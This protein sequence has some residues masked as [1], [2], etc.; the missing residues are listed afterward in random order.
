MA[1]QA[2]EQLAE[3]LLEF[4]RVHPSALPIVWPP[5]WTR[6][7]RGP[8]PGPCPRD[9]P[10]RPTVPGHSDGMRWPNGRLGTSV[11]WRTRPPRIRAR[12]KQRR[13]GSSRFEQDRLGSAVKSQRPGPSIL[14]PG[15]CIPGNRWRQA[16]RR[17]PA[18]F[19]VNRGNDLGLSVQEL[20]VLSADESRINPV[21]LIGAPPTA[22]NRP[23][24][25][26][27]ALQLLT[28]V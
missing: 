20:E 8:R 7:L 24:P 18:L 15:P 19:A 26:F 21:A 13:P 5:R 12:V 27:V 3:K 23:R 11:W 2:P 6:R 14:G 1:E 22:G 9:R 10:R 17:R 25:R 4:L 28:S 16:R